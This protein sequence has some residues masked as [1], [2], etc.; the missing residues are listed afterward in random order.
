MKKLVVLL[1]LFSC[2]ACNPGKQTA[3]ALEQSQIFGWDES[4]KFTANAIGSQTS[5]FTMAEGD[6][7]LNDDGTINFAESKIVAYLQADPSA[8]Q[9][10]TVAGSFAELSAQQTTATLEFATA[11]V[12]AFA[13]RR[14]P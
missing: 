3:I 9:A 12:E 1:L 13:V 2:S 5:K 7:V 8:Q 11:I 10:A 14:E 4:G 6:I